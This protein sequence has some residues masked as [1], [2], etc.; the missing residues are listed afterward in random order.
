MKVSGLTYVPWM[1]QTRSLNFSY[2]QQKFLSA[3]RLPT[4]GA[5]NGKVSRNAKKSCF[6]IIF[7][8]LDRARDFAFNGASESFS[9]HVVA[10]LRTFVFLKV[11]Q[12]GVTEDIKRG[13]LDTKFDREITVT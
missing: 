9:F 8:P 6:G 7:I 10:E 1:L 13:K 3:R 12:S 5:K 2:Q 4:S 11:K